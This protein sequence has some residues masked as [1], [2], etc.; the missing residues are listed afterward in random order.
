MY[1]I[2]YRIKKQKIKQNK[3]EKKVPMVLTTGTKLGVVT[4]QSGNMFTTGCQHQPV[5]KDPL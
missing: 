2:E 4:G 1:N 3:N 5:L